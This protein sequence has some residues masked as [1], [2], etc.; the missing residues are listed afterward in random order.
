M[1]LCGAAVVGEA[2]I[3]ISRRGDAVVY[4]HLAALDGLDRDQQRHY[5]RQARRLGACIGV[6]GK[7]QP[8]ASHVADEHTSC[9]VDIR[10]IERIGRHRA[11]E[12]KANYKR[13]R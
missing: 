1:Y 2:K 13:K 10:R 5:L 6:F 3:A 11:A 4:R 9:G 12:H 7:Q 8:A